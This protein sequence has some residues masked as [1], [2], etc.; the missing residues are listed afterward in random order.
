MGEMKGCG[1]DH[2]AEKEVELGYELRQ[3]GSRCWPLKPHT[4]SSCILPD[5]PALG[6]T[7]VMERR[8]AVVQNI[9]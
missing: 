3:L 8:S 6:S 4:G 9:Q 1:Q 2:T 7:V 5:V